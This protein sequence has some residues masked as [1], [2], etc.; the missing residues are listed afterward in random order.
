[1]S[2][3]ICNADGTPHYGTAH[4]R[5]DFLYRAGGGFVR[6]HSGRCSA[7]TLTQ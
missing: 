2:C 4:S 3:P 5:R 1:M 6:S 7:A